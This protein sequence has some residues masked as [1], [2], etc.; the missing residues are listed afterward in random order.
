MA[1]AL[2]QKWQHLGYAL[3]NA[4]WGLGGV[5]AQLLLLYYLTEIAGLPAG[6]AGL[7]LALPKVWDALVDPAFGGWI[8]RVSIRSG[9]RA[10]A[11]LIATAMFVITLIL[12]FSLPAVRLPHAI[13]AY[14]VVLLILSSMAQTAIG[15]SQYAM[16][17]E[18][19]TNS[20]G[21]SRL[22]SL[23]CV[24]GQ[25]FVVAG[26]IL[27]PLLVVRAGGGRSGYSA[28]ATE[29][30]IV[31]GLALVIFVFAT[32]RVPVRG[33]AA[34]ASD[35]SLWASLWATRTNRAFYLLMGFIIC[36]N[37]SFVV[38]FAVL[39]FANQYVLA[40]SPGSLSIL[41]GILGATALA[42]M[43][44]APLL[45]R[46]AS[47]VRAMQLCNAAV[48]LVLIALF[49][50]SFGPIWVSWLA[51]GGI[52]L[53]LGAI[54]VLVQ[55]AVLATTRIRLPNS[56]VVAMGFYL[57]IMLAGIKLGNSAGG[58]S[59]GELLDFIGFTPGHATQAPSALAGLRAGYT[60]VPLALIVLGGA[61]LHFV[62]IPPDDQLLPCSAE[63][64]G[65]DS[66]AQSCVPEGSLDAQT[67]LSV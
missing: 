67:R 40:R 58:F 55:A 42:G 35:L 54:G 11:V 29:I 51:L 47:S 23:A 24:I 26:G 20:A 60:L 8:D 44:L 2:R 10:P 41:E 34:E 16:A 56:S 49:A 1:T 7:A 45:V 14:A 6:L 61:F 52:G 64:V 4:G 33:R 30:A 27:A 62:A 5:P 37:A 12:V 38:I 28:M 3:S 36:Q 9:T 57:G 43:L 50:A 65:R 22:L 25:V 66:S 31:S 19:T 21:L 15:V 13:L 17:T 46:R 39:P 63:P 32:R 48:A 18:M 53:G 59:S